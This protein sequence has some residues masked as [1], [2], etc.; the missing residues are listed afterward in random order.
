MTVNELIEELKKRN[1]DLIVCMNG[2]E[3]G[4]DDLS[5]IEEIKLTLNG[6]SWATYGG[7]HDSD[8]NS[9]IEALLL[10]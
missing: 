10:R 4:Y 2:Q 7:I 9:K 5:A 3:F 8:E 1:G 6:N